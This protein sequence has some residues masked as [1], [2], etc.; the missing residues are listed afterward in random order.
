MN[1]TKAPRL[2]VTP[3]GTTTNFSALQ[4]G[5]N[6]VTL[7]ANV[8]RAGLLISNCGA[9]TMYV[10]FGAA[11]AIAGAGTISIP[12]NTT[13]DFGNAALPSENIQVIGTA[14]DRFTIKEIS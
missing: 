1:L 12:A 6:I 3:T 7:A 14:G 4:T 10:N 2:A 9:A 5:A 13:M 8:L 11:A